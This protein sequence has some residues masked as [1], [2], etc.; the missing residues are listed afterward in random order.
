MPADVKQGKPPA[1]SSQT[2]PGIK[3]E[4][5][6]YNGPVARRQVLMFGTRLAEGD[7]RS[8]FSQAIDMGQFSAQFSLDKFSRRRCRRGTGCEQRTP[9]G[10]PSR[11]SAGTLAMPI[12]T[13]GAAQNMVIS[14]SRISL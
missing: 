2:Q 11:I 12:S 9:R 14:S 5:S 7:Q 10:A 4:L 8:G 1:K 6:G 13:V 3:I